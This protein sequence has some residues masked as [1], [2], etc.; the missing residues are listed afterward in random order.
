M[1]TVVF[2]VVGTKLNYL[3][4]GVVVFS[5]VDVLLLVVFCCWGNN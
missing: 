4:R 1:R 2:I 5:P 3:R